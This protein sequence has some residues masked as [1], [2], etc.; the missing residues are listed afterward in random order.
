M[1]T[2][3]ETAAIDRRNI[4]SSDITQRDA[5]HNYEDVSEARP[6]SIFSAVV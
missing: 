1:L 5:K 4:Y 6:S 3:G 2:V